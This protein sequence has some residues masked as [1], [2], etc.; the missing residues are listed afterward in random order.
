MSQRDERPLTFEE[1]YFLDNPI[2][3]VRPEDSCRG[4]PGQDNESFEA[5]I[6]TR[7][8]SDVVLPDAR[9]A[10]NIQIRYSPCTRPIRPR[11]IDSPQ[12]AGLPLSVLMRSEII[13][14]R[15][16]PWCTIGKIFV[17]KD[18]D[19]ANPMWVGSG[20]LVGPNLLLTASH[21]APWNFPNWWMR[22][23]P[24]YRNGATPFGISYVQSYRGVRNTDDV[25]G[26]DYVICKLYTRLGDNIGYMGSWFWSNDSPYLD[27]RWTS[28]GY[29][30]DS[31]GGQVPMVELD[32]A[33][34]DIDDEGSSGKELESY[35]FSTGGWSGG[36]LWGWIGDQ[37]R[38]VGVMSGNE[39]EL[40]FWDFFTA[41]HSVSAGG[42]HMVDLVKYG[43]S[44]WV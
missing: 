28:V 8:V 44:N 30:G 43:W 42:G 4:L 17:G 21:V 32:I 12:L 11:H 23:V 15:T 24:A 7:L 38:I 39:E 26:L 36:P 41:D 9:R 14:E 5:E 3:K 37:P 2:E 40:S 34:D 29:P 16:W 13:T 20:A 27:G 10:E 25:T 33:L 31:S 35:V 1:A 22:F 18:E 6:L 19:Y